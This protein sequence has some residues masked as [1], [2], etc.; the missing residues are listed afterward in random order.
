MS[1]SPSKYVEQVISLF[2]LTKDVEADGQ[3]QSAPTKAGTRTTPI[4]ADHGSMIDPPTEPRQG[5]DGDRLNERL[6]EIYAIRGAREGLVAG[7]VHLLNTDVV[8]DRLG[9]RWPRFADRVHDIIRAELNIRLG[10]Q[11]LFARVRGDAYVIVFGDCSEVEACLKVAMLSERILHTL[12]GEADASEIQSLGV[13]RLVARGDGSIAIEA[14]DSKEALLS[15]L[16][17]AEQAGTA[18]Q[19]YDCQDAIA[20]R[21]ALKPPEAEWL[22]SRLRKELEALQ[23]ASGGAESADAKNDGL[24][25][26]VKQLAAIEEAMRPEGPAFRPDKKEWSNWKADESASRILE[27][28]RIARDSAERLIA[29][30]PLDH[31]ASGR[32]DHSSSQPQ[33]EFTYQPMWH[34]P[35]NRVGVYLCQPLLRSDGG[36]LPELKAMDEDRRSDLLALVDRLALRKARQ[37]LEKTC[38]KGALNVIMIPVHFSTLWRYGNKFSFLELCSQMP[39]GKVKALSWEIVDAGPETWKWQLKEIVEMLLPFG[40]AVFLRL[41]NPIAEM[42]ELHRNLPY[43]RA[44][45]I[46]AVGLDVADLSGSETEKLQLLETTAELAEQSGLKCYGHGLDSLSIAICT[47]CMGY[48]HVSGQA[49]AAPTDKPAGIRATEME[50]IY[51]RALLKDDVLAS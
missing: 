25:R 29:S 49:I 18:A 28:I 12:L 47:V 9:D 15:M 37:D 1:G 26:L 36:E 17:R 35:S 31:L 8:R 27:E 48:Q 45:G 38:A 32:P 50:N 40:S 20:D 4:A 3:G 6:R 23:G 13:Q 14:I 30:S 33:V 44:A 43:L 21:R 51:S 24:E 16:D 2:G 5:D 46:H 39:A 34:T 42:P 11:D 41:P 10:P 22:F 7:R 19:T